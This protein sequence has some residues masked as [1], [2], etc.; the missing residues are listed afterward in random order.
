MMA[1]VEFLS[2]GVGRRVSRQD[3][4]HSIKETYL[5]D[6]STPN[7][8]SVRPEPITPVLKTFH[9]GRH[10]WGVWLA[11]YP[12]QYICAATYR[13][14]LGRAKAEDSFFL[15]MD[16]LERDLA[17]AAGIRDRF[18][19]AYAAV[20]ERR[21]AGLGASPIAA[22]WHFVFAV[23]PWLQS[24]AQTKARLL[25][26]FSNGDIKIDA[27]NPIGG[28]AHYLAKLVGNSD[29]EIRFYNLDRL[30]YAGPADLFDAQ[31][32]DPYV[33]D[34]FRYSLSGQTFVLRQ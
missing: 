18:P 26:T 10:Q 19:V 14:K 30:T 15:F 33:P 12:W 5:L 29:F 7:F 11:G 4:T 31:Q 1:Y 6:R 21:A 34:H 28:G 25:W 27:Y 16:R 32:T 2:E 9:P 24:R 8:L 23:P 17:K 3:K 20:M 13:D 22:H